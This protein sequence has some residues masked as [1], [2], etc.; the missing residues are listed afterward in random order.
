MLVTAG[1][2]VSPDLI[3]A[4]QHAV[5]IAQLN[6]C[7]H[8]FLGPYMTSGVVGVAEDHN[9]RLLLDDL[10]FHILD[11]QGPAISCFLNRRVND[12]TA[13]VSDSALETSVAGIVEQDPVAGQRVSLNE[14]GNAAQNAVLVVNLISG[15]AVYA[16]SFLLPLSDT[17]EVSLRN[18]E[19]TECMMF[20]SLGHRV[21]DAVRSTE[22]HIGNPHG[23]DILVVL[24]EQG[25]I[26]LGS[27]MA[28]SFENFIK[29]LSI[30]NHF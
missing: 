9:G 13:A 5:L 28:A 3:G 29:E 4:D 18:L 12:V 6:N 19:V 15:Y 16:I 10:L 7:D 23:N 14:G 22:V 1:L 21:N 2:E 8:F 26:P 25:I 17:I 11:V 24:Y 27:V 30:V 20:Q